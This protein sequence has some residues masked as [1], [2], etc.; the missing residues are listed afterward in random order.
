MSTA[1]LYDKVSDRETSGGDF[2]FKARKRSMSSKVVLDANWGQ[3]GNL[4]EE[5]K[6]FLSEFLG[7]CD[8]SNLALAKFRSESVENVGLRFL[9][10]RNFSV[11]K[12]LT[13]LN[14]CAQRKRDGKASIYAGMTADECGNCNNDALRI[15]YPHSTIGYDKFNRPILFEQ[16]GKVD[17]AAIAQM[18]TMDQLIAYHWWSMDYHLNEMLDNAPDRTAD[19]PVSTLCIMDLAGLNMS[20]CSSKMMDHLKTLVTIDNT[21]YPEILGKMLVINAPW[22]A[23]KKFFPGNS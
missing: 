20:H 5:Q 9:R 2:N 3:L 21:C 6:N 8:Q 10:A 1:I 12:A 14:D 18:I 15:W 22:L 16:S 23:G 17:Q 4:T 19:T 7:S 13:L 11:A